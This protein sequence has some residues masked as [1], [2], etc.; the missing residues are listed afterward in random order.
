MKIKS[1]SR[2]L[3]AG[4]AVLAISGSDRLTAQ[5]QPAPAAYVIRGGTLIDG[6]GGAPLANSVIVVQGDRITAA[7]AAG[8]VQVP[9]GAEEID[10]TGKWI[11][12]GLIDAKGNWNWN[13]A[14]PYLMW[15]VTSVVVSGGRNNQ[16]LAERDAINHGMYR[17]PRLFMTVA[18]LNGPGPDQDRPDNYMP[19]D[20]NRIVHN[21]EESVAH[22][23][24]LVDVGADL[25]T[26]QNGDGPPE[27]FAPAVAEAQA[28]GLGI[29]FRA[30]G[31]QSRAREVCEMGDG[32][33]YVHTGNAGSQMA[34]DESKWAT[35][36]GLPPDAYADMDPGK[37]AQM[38]QHLIG[39]NA[40]LE[41][42]L[43][44]TGRGFHKNWARVQQEDRDFLNDPALAAYF[45]RHS[46]RGVIE[47]AKSPDTYL[48]AE[49]L[50]M[51]T[52]GFANHVSF[53]KAFVDAGGHLVAASD[54][55]QTHPGLGVHQEMTAIVEDVGLT[56]M[57]GILSG[58]SWVADGFRL[59]DVGRIEAGKLANI[60]IVNADPTVD[61]L[62]LRQID[63]VMKEGH[64]V[65]RHY[66]PHYVGGSIFQN[67]LDEDYDINLGGEGWMEALKEATWRPNARNGGF[68]NSGGFD[69]ELAP[70]PGIENFMPH[71]IL[72]G[73]GETTIQITG[74]NFVQGSQV[75]VDGQAVPTTAKSRTEIEA[76][77]PAGMFADAG[78]LEVVV[79]NPMPLA[80]PVWG[81]TSNIGYVLVPYEFTKILPQ[82]RW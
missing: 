78:K 14:E 13:Y 53:L 33:V 46:Y 22:I 28:H 74:F 70:T 35:Y 20:G 37:E 54:A 7:G 77:I 32:L 10:A 1:F 16:G 82:P 60:V 67:R 38:I 15:G 79:R 8:A 44:A 43:M 50:D 62:N 65:D 30:M 40:Y 25:V 55:P 31:P 23:R 66:D 11:V 42:D 9:A 52:R 48:N 6:N 17:G 59:A 80:N 2:P 81:D 21:G 58:T 49:A 71:T 39:C 73:A 19:G 24:A 36:I 26:F 76:R 63:S 69:S 41:P 68:G 75:L 5:A 57:Q 29:D 12:P 45:P 47:N 61:I 56:P 27:V 72:R 64:I 34:A 51:R 18:T 4:L 3:L